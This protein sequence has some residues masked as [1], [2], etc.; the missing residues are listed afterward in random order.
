MGWSSAAALNPASIKPGEW[1]EAPASRM[2]AVKPDPL[3]NGYF[4][5]EME[6]WSGGAYDSKRDRLMIWGGGH[7]D[8]AGNEVY[9]FDLDALKWERLNEPSADVG[10]DEPSGVYPDGLPRARHTYNYVQYVTALD[11]FCTLGGAGLYPSGQTGTSKTHCFDPAGKTWER[12]SDAIGAGIG[13]VSGEDAATGMIWVQGGGGS[14][15]FSMWDPKSDKWTRYNTYEKGWFDYTYT[16]AAGGGI[17]L[18]IGNGKALVWDV[19]NPAAQ[20]IEPVMTGSKD[21][22]G[23]QCPG[24]AYDPVRKRF[25]AWAGGKDVY[26]LDPSTWVWSKESIAPG[27][28]VTPTAAEKNGTYGRFRYIPSRDLF[29]AVN[30]TSENVFLFRPSGTSR[31]L[32]LDGKSRSVRS[33]LSAGF[34][35]GEYGAFLW[36]A[37]WRHGA[38]TADG[39]VRALGAAKEP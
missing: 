38:G 35:R 14:A 20:P 18:A 3:P 4:S 9:A 16:G 8:Y 13:A 6:A 39:R 21:I 34:T 36:E 26:S 25:A 2:D 11:R 30:R 17:F 33:G 15:T 1:F 28:T 22:L 24:L 32:P 23:I 12:K 37:E 5:A 10:G 7:S 19:K 29:I 27:N 31:I